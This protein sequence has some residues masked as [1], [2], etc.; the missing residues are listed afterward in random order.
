MLLA[1]TRGNVSLAARIAKKERRTFTRLLKKHAIQR[2][3]YLQKKQ[4]V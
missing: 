4:P 2:M 3:D 1:K